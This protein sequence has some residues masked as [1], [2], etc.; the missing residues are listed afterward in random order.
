M[1]ENVALINQNINKKALD[2]QA[3]L[4]DK[5]VFVY[6]TL[7]VT[8]INNPKTG[9]P[10]LS[11]E[12]L[13]T[14]LYN[15]GCIHVTIDTALLNFYKPGELNGID[16][17]KSTIGVLSTKL[18]ISN[19]N[20][21]VLLVGYGTD[22]GTKKQFW[23]CK[24]S[25]GSLW[26]NHGYFAVEFVTKPIPVDGTDVGA[27][28]TG[29]LA[30][31]KDIS[32][33]SFNSLQNILLNMPVV[34]KYAEDPENFEID[35]QDESHSFTTDAKKVSVTE[36]KNY[37][38]GYQQVQI[39]HVESLLEPKSTIEKNLLK[40]PK[41]Y[42]SSYSY[43]DSMHNRFNVAISGPVL[44]QGLCNSSW[45]FAGCQ[46]LSSSISILLSLAH[47]KRAYVS[48]SPTFLIQKICEK[49]KSFFTV[50]GNP[51]SGG[52]ISLFLLAVNGIFTKYDYNRSADEID[53]E[54]TF[55][56]VVPAKLVPYKLQD[57]TCQS[58]DCKGLPQNILVSEILKQELI[59]PLQKPLTDLQRQKV[60][61]KFDKK[62]KD[63]LKKEAQ[64]RK[65][66]RMSKKTTR[67]RSTSEENVQAGTS[68]RKKL[69][70]EEQQLTKQLKT[71][72]NKINRQ[73]ELEEK[74]FQQMENDNMTTTKE[75]YNMTE[76]EL[77]VN[78]MTMP[79]Y[80]I[81]IILLLVLGIVLFI[82]T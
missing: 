6:I 45:A 60:E 38:T 65:N 49:N 11:N 80:W 54:T 24:N 22:Q 81:S 51:C 21:A 57:G 1:A 52:N 73:L 26:G 39:S 20:H 15:Y 41:K 58:C 72:Q 7:N 14:L 56:S 42:Q 10:L 31:F 48:L 34:D 53:G 47:R 37:G 62:L 55:N 23:I 64:R 78:T 3:N 50:G 9:T 76:T 8:N 19:P 59:L 44:N 17:E 70:E 4:L 36:N 74:I 28:A 33:I 27:T 2:N 13:K 67:P 43:T 29:P 71:L 68:L 12:Q 25:W 82:R 75:N 46:L 69:E 61:K 35:F 30:L 16:F 18:A 63:G 32:Y 5:G 40:I 77:K 66:E 79:W